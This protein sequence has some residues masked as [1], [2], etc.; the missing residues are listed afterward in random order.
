MS[1][2]DVIPSLYTDLVWLILPMVQTL[3]E[4]LNLLGPLFIKSSIVVAIFSVAARV[5]II[6]VQWP[7]VAAF[8]DIHNNC[9]CYQC[10]VYGHLSHPGTWLGAWGPVGVDGPSGLV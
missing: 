10:D 5:W 6:I 1:I 2:T 4:F 3:Q 7:Y 9:L 8:Y